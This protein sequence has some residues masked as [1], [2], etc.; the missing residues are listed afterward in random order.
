LLL[1]AIL[2]TTRLI[3]SRLRAMEPWFPGAKVRLW[4]R[5]KE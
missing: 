5:F 3:A 4:A 2:T 1:E